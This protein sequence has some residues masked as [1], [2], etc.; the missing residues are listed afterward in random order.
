MQSHDAFLVMRIKCN[1]ELC[2][3]EEI[4]GLLAH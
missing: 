2:R 4:S 3:R 1:I